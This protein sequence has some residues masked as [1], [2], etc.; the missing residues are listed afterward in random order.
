MA[1]FSKNKADEIQIPWFRKMEPEQGV[2][3]A[4]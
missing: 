2:I 3:T 1:Y 4:M